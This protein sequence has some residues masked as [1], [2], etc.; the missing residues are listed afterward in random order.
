MAQLVQSFG[1]DE[2]A[3]RLQNEELVRQMYWGH[4]WSRLAIGVNLSLPGANATFGLPTL[5][6]GLCQGTTNGTKSSSTV[7]F[8]GARITGQNFTYAAGPPARVSF[9]Q[10]QWVNKIGAVTTSFGNNS[11]TQYIGVS[12]RD[13][14]ILHIEQ[15][16]S[17]YGVQFRLPTAVPPVDVF[18]RSFEMYSQQT[19]PSGGIP[20]NAVNFSSN[21]LLDTVSIYWDYPS[22]GLEISEILVVRYA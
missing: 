7:E 4:N 9:S 22:V 1:A 17:G 20:Y 14:A 21:R 15:T 10:Y 2:T 18:G 12:L 13:Y 16:A 8:V 5:Y 3:L 11:I 6:V 19:E